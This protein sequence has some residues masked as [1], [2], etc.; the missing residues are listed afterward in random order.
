VREKALSNGR[1]IPTFSGSKGFEVVGGGEVDPLQYM[2]PGGQ[3]LRAFAGRQNVSEMTV[4]GNVKRK[5][6]FQ[7]ENEENQGSMEAFEEPLLTFHC[8]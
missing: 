8:R 1:L 5:G 3:I 7:A 2:T 4:N 6:S